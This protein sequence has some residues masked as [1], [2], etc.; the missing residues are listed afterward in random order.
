MKF[1]ETAS[2]GFILLFVNSEILVS[3]CGCESDSASKPT[4]GPAPGAISAANYFKE[5]FGGRTEIYNNRNV[6]GGKSLSLHAEGRAVDLYV[7]GETGKK[8]FDH[9]VTIACN[10]GIQEV[11]FNRR[12]WTQSGSER[13][14]GGKHPHDDHVHIGL[15]K[16]GAQHFTQ[17]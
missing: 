15:N 12:I 7:S 17:E 9:A 2:L 4:D 14:Y 6:R 11:I 5:K 13:H 3:A 16:C 10:S 1:Y 8:A